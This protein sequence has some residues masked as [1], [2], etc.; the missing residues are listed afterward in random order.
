MNKINKNEIE[1]TKIMLI[2]YIICT[3]NILNKLFKCI[4][5]ATIPLIHA[6]ISH[7]VMFAGL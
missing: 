3:T 4:S 5:T 1:K 7:L 6:F 2:L